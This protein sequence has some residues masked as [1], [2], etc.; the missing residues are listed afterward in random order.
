MTK[1]ENGKAILTRPFYL[2]MDSVL[3]QG[4]DGTIMFQANKK[5]KLV[6]I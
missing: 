5:Y 6:V 1:F 3:K 4:G 2:I